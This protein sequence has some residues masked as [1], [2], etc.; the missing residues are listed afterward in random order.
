MFHRIASSASRGLVS[1]QRAWDCPLLHPNARLATDVD[2]YGTQVIAV[3]K[4]LQGVAALKV[5]QHR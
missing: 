5:G 2:D 3:I 4:K 1:R